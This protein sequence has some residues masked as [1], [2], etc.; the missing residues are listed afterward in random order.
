MIKNLK[1]IGFGVK[2]GEEC[3]NRSKGV[4]V[5]LRLVCCSNL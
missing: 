5:I 4:K 2:R 1:D 3:S